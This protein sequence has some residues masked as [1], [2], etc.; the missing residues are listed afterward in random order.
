MSYIELSRREEKTI[1]TLVEFTFADG[2][3]KEIEVSHFMP[4]DEDEIQL[5]LQNRLISEQ[6][7]IDDALLVN[8]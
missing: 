8:E 5:G 6:K 1:K 4:K 2:S 7:A 3:V